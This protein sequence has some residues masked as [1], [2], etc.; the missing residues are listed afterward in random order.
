MLKKILTGLGVLVVLALIVIQF[1]RPE[2]NNSGIYTNDITTAYAVPAEV[3]QLLKVSCFDCH[4][5]M[6]RYPWYAEVQPVGWWL[7][8]HITEGKRHLN[9]SDF[10]GA[11]LFVQNRR[12]DEIVETVEEKEMPIVSYTFL[13]MHSDA[14]LSDAQRK[15]IVDWAKAQMTY[16]QNNYPADSLAFPRREGQR[17][18]RD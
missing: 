12:F 17:P 2:K 8:N 15:M 1:I 10:T 6:T 18:P 9:F 14:N 3:D 4:S 16:L 11:P 13:G 7:N 5:N